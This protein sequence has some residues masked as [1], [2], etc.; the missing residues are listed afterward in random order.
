MPKKKPKTGKPQLHKDLEG[1]EMNINEF[2]EITSTMNVEKVNEFLN[3]N[4]DD[5]KFKER[6]DEEEIKK[7][8]FVKKEGG[9]KKGK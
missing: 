4:V 5:K 3:R 9:K 6:T 1:F 7:G 2:G 8:Q